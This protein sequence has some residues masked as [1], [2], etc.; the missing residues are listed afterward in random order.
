MTRRKPPRGPARPT[1]QPRPSRSA[2]GTPEGRPPE[3]AARAERPE[4]PER[5]G[6]AERPARPERRPGETAATHG[7]LLYGTHAVLAALANPARRCR[8]L[9]LTEEAQRREGPALEGLA[10]ARGA[11]L[12]PERIGRE[13]LDALLPG[14]V[15][16]GLALE[17]DPL[18]PPFLEELLAGLPEGPALLVLLDQ[19]TDPHNVGAVLRSAAVF[20]AAAVVATERHAAA[21]SGALAKAASG[22]LERVPYLREVNLARSLD[23]LKQA[24]F[25]ALGFA[26]E[27]RQ[28]LAGYDPPERLALCLG[29]EG[30]GLR[31]LTR[32]RCD[33]LLALPAAGDFRDLNVSNAAA[34]ALYALTAKRLGART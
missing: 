17:T 5:P 1:R 11:T 18:Q 34:I 10:R 27:A 28:P 2:Q 12:V 23:L 3:R 32:E 13:A 14:A 7:L 4:R 6:R 25:W 16:Q 26:S 9:L 15:H 29:A 33:L 21:E 31:R 20:G 24:G 30:A 8:R 19:V 22:A